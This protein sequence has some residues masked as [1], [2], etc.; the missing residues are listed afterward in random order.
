MRGCE[1]V[2]CAAVTWQDLADDLLFAFDRLEEINPNSKW[3][4]DH[5]A[6]LIRV[7]ND[8]Q[9]LTLSKC[10]LDS[11]EAVLGG[12]TLRI[13]LR[14]LPSITDLARDDAAEVP[15]AIIDR[16]I[17]KAAAEMLSWTKDLD[18]FEL[19]EQRR[20]WLFLQWPGGIPALVNEYAYGLWDE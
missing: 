6:I 2:D 12:Q 4:E 9:S 19:L 18:C 5:Q 15:N 13:R 14:P 11:G 17:S 16:A 7:A 20:Y 1:L 10:P 3:T 8:M